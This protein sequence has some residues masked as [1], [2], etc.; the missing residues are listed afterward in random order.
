MRNV[1]RP[2][3]LGVTLL[4]ACAAAHAQP[5]HAPSE[6]SA[7]CRAASLKYLGPS[8]DKKHLTV[9]A[10]DDY[11]YRGMKKYLRV[12]GNSDDDLTRRIKQEVASHEAAARSCDE[13]RT[14][15]LSQFRAPSRL[16]DEHSKQNFEAA[17]EFLRDC[18]DESEPF[19]RYV[20]NWVSKYEKAIREFEEKKRQDGDPTTKGPA[21]EQ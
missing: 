20:S 6:P 4:C 21:R 14:E 9:E 1:V 11:E 5:A 17:K 8:P 7:R 19:D 16:T 2:I 10:E 15:L 12:C 3:I 18:R 13:R